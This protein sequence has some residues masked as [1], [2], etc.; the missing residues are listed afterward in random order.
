MKKNITASAA[1]LLALGYGL[2]AT[3]AAAQATAAAP[4]AGYYLIVG[5][6]APK[7]SKGIY[8]FRFHPATG[9]ADRVSTVSDIDNPTFLA[10]SPDNNYLYAVSETKGGSGGGV[11][12]Y[13][14]DRHTG[15]LR[16]L[17]KRLSEGDNP[18]NIITDA[19]GKWVFVSNYTSGSLSVF[20][21]EPDGSLGPIAQHIQHEGHSVTKQQ[22]SAHVHCVMP[23]PGGRDVF[24]TDLGMDRVFTYELDARTGHLSPGNPPYT[25]VRAGS[26][27][28]HM[29][30]SPDGRFMYLIQE[31]GGQVTVFRYTPGKLT[32]VQEVSNIPE[33]FQG[34]IW[35]ADLHLSPDG[36]FLYA[37]NRDDL[38]DI[39]TYRVDK[40]TG[41]LTFV[42]RVPSGGKTPRNFALTPDGSFLLAGHKNGDEIAVFKRDARTGLLTATGGKI[43][44]PHAVC[45][46]FCPLLP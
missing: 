29:I 15:S 8:V 17:N 30:F 11:C 5:S 6:Y 16:F 27:P 14:F 35:A 39:V 9:K 42:N 34:R 4:A 37:A 12:A 22:S 31:I 26:G 7:E 28:R 2:A 13:A 1:G 18:C 23:A 10:L 46:K 19:S 20:P 45:L 44:V 21:V 41:K 25:P 36:R 32:Q 40:A 24:V 43:Q 38:N 33:G 3:P